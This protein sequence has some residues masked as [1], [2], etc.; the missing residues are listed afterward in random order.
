MSADIEITIDTSDWD[1]KSQALLRN[2][3]ALPARIL[4][5]GSA[6]VEEEMRGAVPVRTGRL[7]DSIRRQIGET[8]A[9]VETSSGYGRIVDLGSA[10]HVIKARDGGYL[11]FEIDGTVIFRK[12][13]NHPGF[14]GRFFTR[15]TV[16]NSTG[17][18]SAM[19]KNV[20]NDLFERGIGS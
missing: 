11:R 13:V 4:D 9:S 12:Q 7:R 20:L 1:K 8:S 15:T 6:I 2:L 5:E 10:S 19:I 14:T 17:R 18:L 3:P 16:Q